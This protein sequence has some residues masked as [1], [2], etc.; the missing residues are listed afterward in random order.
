MKRQ[1][2]TATLALCA[3]L[4]PAAS[5]FAQDKPKAVAVEAIKD[6]G[7]IAK[8]EKVVNDFTIRND[9]TAVLKITEVRPACGCTVASF[10]A[11]VAP[12]QTGKVHVT[13]DTVTFNGPIAKGV[14]VYTNDPDTPQIEL[15]LKV[16][17]QPYISV[18][19]GYARYVTVHGEAKEG[20]IV[21]T[22]WTPDSSPLNILKVD[23]PY[24]YLTVSFHE[25][26]DKE[27]LPDAPGKQ[28]KVEMLLSSNAPVGPL[29]D[30]VTVHTDHPKQKLVQ[31]PI[32]GFVRPVIAVTP[33]V[34]DF[35]QIELKAPLSKTLDVRNF[36]T[37]PIKITSVDEQG[38]GIKAQLEPQEEG[39]KYFIHVTL[40]PEVGKGPFTAKLT[41]HTDSPKSPV[42]EVPLKGTVL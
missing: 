34:G 16:R 20:T 35:G 14:T 12:G 22:L 17:V 40:N 24:P 38:K 4:L 31:I 1:L 25:A 27:R 11:T 18:K 15:T 8:G 32:S 30:V 19:P 3:A 42:I 26:T 5:L 33:P 36:A 37:E 7:V 2:M 9:G 41:I 29:A 21:Q 13:L 39:R 28:W 6:V 23:S 10:D